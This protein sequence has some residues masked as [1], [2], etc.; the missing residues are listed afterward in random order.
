VTLI[1]P[2]STGGTAARNSAALTLL[3]AFDTAWGPCFPLRPTGAVRCT[4][5]SGA[6]TDSAR[7]STTTGSAAPISTAD[8]I[9][10]SLGSSG[11]ES[12]AWPLFTDSAT[13]LFPPV[14]AP[15]TSGHR[16][17]RTRLFPAGSSRTPSTLSAGALRVSTAHGV[18]SAHAALPAPLT[19]TSGKS[20]LRILRGLS[21]SDSLCTVT[22]FRR[23]SCTCDRAASDHRAATKRLALS[24]EDRLTGAVWG[25][26]SLP[27]AGGLRL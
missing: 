1:R 26:F 22:L 14:P 17:R 12:F 8:P 19:T 16:V 18:S 23:G 5:S 10:M 13:S 7:S 9:T 20:V 4:Q 25:P 11:P 24:R 2:T 21:C 3:A 6:P 27:I 15:R